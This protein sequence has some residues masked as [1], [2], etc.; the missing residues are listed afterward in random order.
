[1]WAGLAT[2]TPKPTRTTARKCLKQAGD[3]ISAEIDFLVSMNVAASTNNTPPFA[4][5]NNN[6]FITN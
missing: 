4:R 6:Y 3:V 2:T 5:K 1:V